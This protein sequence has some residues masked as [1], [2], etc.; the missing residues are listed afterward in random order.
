[1]ENSETNTFFS[2]DALEKFTLVQGKT[3]KKIICHMW[4]NLINKD[5]PVELIDNVQLQFSDDSRLT[6]ASNEEGEGLEAI[7]YDYKETAIAL[8]KEFEGK[9]RL[10]ALDASGTSMWEKVVGSTLVAVQLTKQD[11]YYRADSV[12]LNFGEEKRIITV[13]PLDGVIIDYHEED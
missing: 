7:E 12:L 5:A 10:L 4:Q 13:T 9:I 3:V 1:M 6:I 8:H 2:H 11:E